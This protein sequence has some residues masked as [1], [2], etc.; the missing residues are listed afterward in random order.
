LNQREDKWNQIQE[1]IEDLQDPFLILTANEEILSRIK[2]AYEQ[3]SWRQMFVWIVDLRFIN[4]YCR[5]R[6]GYEKVNIEKMEMSWAKFY[7]PTINEARRVKD[8]DT[9]LLAIGYDHYLGIDEMSVKLL[10]EVRDETNEHEIMSRIQNISENPMMM[11]EE[12]TI[13]K[14]REFIHEN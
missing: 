7:S 12:V 5:N 9:M 11:H 13:T 14:T 2:G 4:D 10:E 8:I 1:K 3:K 6:P